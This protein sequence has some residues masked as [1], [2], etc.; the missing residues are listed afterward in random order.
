LAGADESRPVAAT[1]TKRK[2]AAILYAD[3]VGYSRIMRV[4][5]VGTHDRL[6]AYRKVAGALVASH[7]GRIVG[8]AGD[9][10]LAD[11]PSVIEAL[12]AAVEIQAALAEHN[13]ELP[14]DRRLE[15]RIGINLGDVIVD[16]D[17]IFGDGVNVAA[18]IQALA[19]PGGIA[20][21]GAVFDQAHNK[22]EY[23]FHDRGSHNVKNIAEPVRVYSIGGV[24]RAAARRYGGALPRRINAVFGALALATVVVGAVLWLLNPLDAFR[25]ASSGGPTGQISRSDR[26]TIAVLPFENRSG[27]PDQDYFSDGVT[28]DVITELG[29]FS[30]L[31][32]LSWS[33]VAPYKDRSVTPDE[34]SRDLGVRYVVGGTLRRA[35]DRL[36][37][38]VQL[39]DAERGVL[40]WS[41][42]YDEQP[43]DIFTVQDKITRQVAGALAVRVTDIETERAFDK[44]TE[45]LGAY[46]LVLRGRDL[47]RRVARDTNLEARAMFRRASAIDPDYSEAYTGE[48]WTHLND[49][50]YGWTEWADRAVERAGDLAAHAIELDERE[51][52]AHVLL[53]E[54]LLYQRD[55][56]RSFQ[57]IEQ[58]IAINPNDDIGRAV[59]GKLMLYTGR[60]AEAVSS[61][62]LALQLNP[63][64]VSWWVE[65]LARAHYFLGNDSEVVRVLDRYSDLVEEHPAAHALRAAALAQLAAGRCGRSGCR[66]GSDQP[67]L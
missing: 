7:S 34:L 63:N 52:S 45:D 32:V 53:G 31:L 10:V 46:D 14:S 39:T 43:E 51:A 12:S 54:V 25:D 5:E 41:G 28:E 47:L 60:P 48:G 55:F 62:D 23:V 66:A 42:R 30:D 19:D 59:Y 2:L 22:V 29:R 56:D 64:P 57:E 40:L 18:R 49:F 6:M 33:A 37:V 13:A 17:D 58:A 35:D 20:V 61:L 9:A 44:P 36:R 67:L 11:F 15:F 8:T 26:P 3:I 24:G 16:G 65:N 4:D 1:G 50:L 38:T 21:S 27:D